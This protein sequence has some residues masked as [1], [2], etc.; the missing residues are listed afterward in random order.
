MRVLRKVGSK[1][2]SQTIVEKEE[3]KD[4]NSS[5]W[6]TLVAGEYAPI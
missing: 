5:D 2:T 6:D 1:T 3:T 4:F